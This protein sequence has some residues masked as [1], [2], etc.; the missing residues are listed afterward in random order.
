[1]GRKSYEKMGVDRLGIEYSIISIL[2][3]FR[4]VEAN[5]GAMSKMCW[6]F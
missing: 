5:K 1:M 4:D 6:F 2:W 3:V